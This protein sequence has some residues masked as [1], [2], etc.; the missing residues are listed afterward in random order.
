MDAE[1]EVKDGIFL[2]FVGL[3]FQECAALYE[4][5]DCPKALLICGIIQ[6]PLV[7]ELGL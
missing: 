1:K 7:D 4:K 2:N 3:V 5:S 6:S